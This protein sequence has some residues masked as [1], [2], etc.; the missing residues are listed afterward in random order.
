MPAAMW[1]ERATNWR[2]LVLPLSAHKP[3]T[4]FLLG[5]I[6]IQTSWS[7]LSDCVP[8]DAADISV[9]STNILDSAADAEELFTFG[10]RRPELR[11]VDILND[12]L[13]QIIS[14]I[15]T[16]RL[17]VTEVG[18]AGWARS[19]HAIIQPGADAER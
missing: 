13:Y 19:I 14:I 15:K 2:R 8:A 9:L 4:H 7:D 10:T 18:V 6:V 1:T 16:T 17:S 12:V 11:G 3:H 5:L